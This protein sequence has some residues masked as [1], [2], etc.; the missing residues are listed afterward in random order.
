VRVGHVVTI[1]EGEHI[2]L[3]AVGV[4]DCVEFNQQIVQLTSKGMEAFHL[5]NDLPGERKAVLDAILADKL[6]TLPA[7]QNLSRRSALVTKRATI[8]PSMVGSKGKGRAVAL[9]RTYVLDNDIEP[10][11]ATVHKRKQVPD[12]STNTRHLRTFL[13]SE[14]SEDNLSQ[15]S[16]SSSSLTVPPRASPVSSL[17]SA[18]SFAY[19]KP[20]PGTEDPLTGAG[21]SL[22]RAINVDEEDQ[23]ESEDNMDD[24]EVAGSE[25]DVIVSKVWPTEFHAVDIVEG[26]HFIHEQGFLGSLIED[27]FSIQFEGNRYV[28][29]TYNDHLRHW[30][31]ASQS[32]KDK[33]LAAGCTP[34]SLW[35]RFMAE[36]PSPYAVRKAAKKRLRN[37]EHRREQ[38]GSP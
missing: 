36:N 38:S 34:A 29:T 22:K 25:E 23:L 28:K 35:S 16:T 27:T 26:F 7:A 31:H 5:R 37:T 8:A 12:E 6:Q 20:E 32:A 33:A 2:F 11:I 10:V 18:S 4:V 1:K 13:H 24:E 21:L 17:S 19:I 9:Q 14:T 15:P 30:T 3:K